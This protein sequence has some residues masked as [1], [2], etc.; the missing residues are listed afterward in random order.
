[1]THLT[2]AIVRKSGEGRSIP[3][4][5][6]IEVKASGDET[7]GSIGVLE[8]TAPPGFGPPRHIHHEADELFYVLEGEV[9]FLLGDEVVRV[10]PGSCVFIP[11][12][13]VH[14]PLVI[15]DGPGRLLLAFVPGGDERQFD[16]F[17]AL[18]AEVGGQLDPGD[19]RVQAIN[20]RYRT[21]WV[22][23]PLE[24]DE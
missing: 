13:T 8:A 2:N 5:P 4:P 12:G 10:G 20:D 11:R 21:A 3:G 17:A 14:A 16:D 15:G 22:G 23:P 24:L 1:M 6:D 9:A 7:G 19:P 18:A